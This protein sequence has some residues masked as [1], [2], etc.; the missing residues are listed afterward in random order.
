MLLA[1]L[2]SLLVGGAAFAQQAAAPDLAGIWQGKLQVDPKT[3]MTIQFT[4]TKKPDGSYSAVLNSPD[5]SSI[6]NV[7]ADPVTWKGGALSVQVASLSGSFAGT[8]S[9]GNISGQWKQPGSALP[10]VLSRYEKPTISKSDANLLVGSWNGRLD[11]PQQEIT[12][13]MDFKLDDKGQLVGTLKLAEQPFPI[14]PFTDIQFAG[15]KLVA[16]VKMNPVVPGQFTAIYANGTLTGVWRAGNPL[17]PPAGVPLVL[18]KGVYVAQV[19]AL[20]LSS[21]SFGMLAGTWTGTLQ[22]PTPQGPHP[23]AIVLR[24]ETNKSAEMVA[25]MD[26]PEQKVTGMAVTDATLT[27]GKVAIKIGAVG[28]EFDATIS[29]NTMT[30]NWI[31]GPGNLPLTMTRK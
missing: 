21:E 27:A 18:K 6:S 15:N 2:L 14:P 31:Q 16:N 4:F 8:L 1:A 28:V 20:K 12:F 5:N 10:L 22:A 7:P 24:F 29:G 11:V 13:L 17:Q 19:H 26:V 9:G 25:F 30:G 3:A 23:L